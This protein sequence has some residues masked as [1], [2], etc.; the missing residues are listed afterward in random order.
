M[1]RVVAAVECFVSEFPLIFEL[2]EQQRD[3]LGSPVG[4]ARSIGVAIVAAPGA[5]NIM[6][7]LEVLGDL[8]GVHAAPADSVLVGERLAEDGIGTDGVVPW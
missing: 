7:S 8:A 5:V 1:L 6:H 3:E 2:V 4:E